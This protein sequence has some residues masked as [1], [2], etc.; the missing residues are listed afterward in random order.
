[1]V[2]CVS[3]F[4][5]QVRG[6]KK[7]IIPAHEVFGGDGAELNDPVRFI[8]TLGLPFLVAFISVLLYVLRVLMRS[9]PARKLLSVLL[10][11]VLL[12]ALV[13][14]A[15]MASWKSVRILGAEEQGS[16]SSGWFLITLLIILLAAW[17][18]AATFLARRKTA[19]VIC[20]CGV[21]AGGHFFVCAGIG[22]RYG[23]L[24]SLSGCIL[25]ALGGLWEAV[26]VP[27]EDFPE[28][29]DTS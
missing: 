25:I 15:V 18:I 26:S 16:G 17:A 11:L 19:S 12:V 9:Q 29:A 14:A 28:Y 4:L 5:P 8:F 7:D 2:L 20:I 6:C 13:S 10:H 22:V 21:A 27:E 1:M 3:F 24:V 23:I